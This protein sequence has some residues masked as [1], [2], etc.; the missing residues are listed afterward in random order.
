MQNKIDRINIAIW[1]VEG[2]SAHGESWIV[3]A[4]IHTLALNIPK[5]F[6][7]DHD[8]DIKSKCQFNVANGY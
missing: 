1:N 4:A 3:K 5:F 7:N 6:A 2:C 8:S